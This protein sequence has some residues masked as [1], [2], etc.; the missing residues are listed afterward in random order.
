MAKGMAII[1]TTKHIWLGL[2]VL[3][4]GQTPHSFAELEIKHWILDY[5]ADTGPMWREQ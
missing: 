3:D 1:G 4:P 5:W 2:V